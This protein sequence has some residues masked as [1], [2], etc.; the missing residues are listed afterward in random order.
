MSTPS[1]PGN[2]LPA[3]NPDSE[4][5]GKFPQWMALQKILSEIP[6][7][8]AFEKSF[9]ALMRRDELMSYEILR[10]PAH[11]V[12]GVAVKVFILAG[13]VSNA[14]HGDLFEI[15]EAAVIHNSGWPLVTEELAPLAIA[16]DILRL[17]PEIVAFCRITL[18]GSL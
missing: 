4:L 11:T 1:Q 7:Q 9:N 14:T 12:K 6:T 18:R 5:W 17:V 8:K 10:T 3:D 2:S 16:D 13:Q 15:D